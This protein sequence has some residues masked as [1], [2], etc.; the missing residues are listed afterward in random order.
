M[1]LR[2]YTLSQMN[3]SGITSSAIEKD[4]I[5]DPF[6]IKAVASGDKLQLFFE[7]QSSH[8]DNRH[9]NVYG[10]AQPFLR[11]GYS[12]SL[13]FYQINRYVPSTWLQEGM[14]KAAQYLKTIIA[15]CDIKVGCD[16]PAFYWQG[17][18]EGDDKKKT[19][20][21]D[22]AGTH[23]KGLWNGRHAERG[24]KIGQQMCKHIYSAANSLRN[25]DMIRNIAEKLG[26]KDTSGQS[27]TQPKSTQPQSKVLAKESIM[28]VFD[29]L[30][31]ESARQ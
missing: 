18:W 2:E 22:F 7:V 27:Q 9:V 11:H 21:M 29:R 3:V 8:D 5:R 12:V 28:N 30:I 10:Q 17:M 20:Y 24:G 6:L 16:C 31:A 25:D 13:A 14:Q 19:D 4:G 23:G 26:V 1:T 15:K